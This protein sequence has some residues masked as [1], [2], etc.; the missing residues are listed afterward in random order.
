MKSSNPS[1]GS[2]ERGVKDGA[3]QFRGFEQ[4]TANFVYCP[5]QF[6]D[7]CLPHHSRGVVRLVGHILRETL[8]WLD[9]N[10]EPIKQNVSVSYRDLTTKAGVSRGAARQAMDE[11]LTAG[12]LSCTDRGHPHASGKVSHTA[13]YALNW[14][15]GGKYI[16]D[17]T[18]FNGFYTGK[19]HRSPIPNAFFDHVVPCETHAVIKVVGVIL[20]HTVGYE[21]Q[22]GGRRANAPLSYSYIQKAMNLRHRKTLAD[23]VQ[24][25]NDK[26]YIRRVVPGHFDPH[27]GAESCATVY[28]VR[29]LDKAPIRTNGSKNEPT[30]RRS[31]NHTGDDSK[32]EPVQRFK[33]RTVINTEQKDIPKQQHAAA[34]LLRDAG[35]DHQVATQ[36]SQRKSAEEIERQIAWLPERSPLKNPLGML[37]R[38]IEENWSE[39]IAVER[40]LKKHAMRERENEQEQEGAAERRAIFEANKK[41]RQR[42]DR[43]R[44]EFLLRPRE[45]RSR[46]LQSALAN[47]TAGFQRDFIRSHGIDDRVVPDVLEVFASE[48]NIA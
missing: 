37:R 18:Q 11:A 43:I 35:F 5:N 48:H 29:W 25:A 12:F 44:R 19:G 46:H 13:T 26:G 22:F 36:L 3:K 33:N 10:G 31:R 39:P 23:A 9:A 14:D 41:R 28:A 8:G 45:E 2:N 47:S 38:A 17:P 1:G 16:T 34:R 32:P 27:G 4:L 6:F 7:V 42:L 40:T 20:R 24:L 30:S 15:H 21:N